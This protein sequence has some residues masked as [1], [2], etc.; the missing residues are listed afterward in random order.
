MKPILPVNVCVS[1]VCLC[2]VLFS[3]FS[4]FSP[5]RWLARPV[6]P[7]SDISLMPGQNRVQFSA[8]LSSEKD[9]RILDLLVIKHLPPL[10]LHWWFKLATCRKTL[11]RS[12]LFIRLKDA[13]SAVKMLLITDAHITGMVIWKCSWGVCTYSRKH[14]PEESILYVCTYTG[15]CFACP[16]GDLHARK[17]NYK[18]W[19]PGR[20]EG[21]SRNDGIKRWKK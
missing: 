12:V 2:L 5:A 15:Q 8:F 19:E 9:G 6:C 13:V 3:P 17:Q 20:E 7:V 21:G 16:Q 4:A 14:H 10:I 1:L 11:I 18:G